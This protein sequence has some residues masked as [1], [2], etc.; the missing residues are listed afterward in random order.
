MGDKLGGRG[1]FRILIIP[2]KR[3]FNC[4]SFF[5]QTHHDAVAVNPAYL[6]RQGNILLEAGGGGNSDRT[7]CG[8]T[9]IGVVGELKLG[10]D[11]FVGNASYFKTRQSLTSNFTVN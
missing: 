11:A 3:L 5:I 7:P 9:W 10:G 4:L 1:F 2:S 8:L 6:T